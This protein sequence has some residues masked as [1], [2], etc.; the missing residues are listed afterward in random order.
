[1]DDSIFFEDSLN[2]ENINPIFD[3]EFYNYLFP[4][5]ILDCDLESIELQE[6]ASNKRKYE[7]TLSHDIKYSRD[8]QEIFKEIFSIYNIY[9]DEYFENELLKSESETSEISDIEFE[10]IHKNYKTCAKCFRVKPLSEF[11]ITIR[12]SYTKVCSFCLEKRKK[13]A[14]SAKERKVSKCEH[15]ENKY[16]CSICLKNPKCI[17]NN[18]KYK[19]SIC[20]KERK[21]CHKISRS[22]CPKCNPDNGIICIH[23][24]QQGECQ[25]CIKKISKKKKK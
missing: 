4:T 9:N 5:D 14:I 1:M 16:K 11:K 23:I 20:I 18:Q 22:M 25:E 8:E 6:K 12:D 10:P 17:H 2:I 24:K 15:T 3:N 7:E 19:C 13:Y 21:C